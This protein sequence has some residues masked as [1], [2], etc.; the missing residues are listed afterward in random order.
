M[1]MTDLIDHLAKIQCGCER[2][3]ALTAMYLDHGTLVRLLQ[4]YGFGRGA[5]PTD[6]AT[7]YGTDELEDFVL[8]Y[9]DQEC[10][11]A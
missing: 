2:R 11:A 7:Y 9:A 6:W 10:A 4:S 5:V 8:D 3:D 1:K